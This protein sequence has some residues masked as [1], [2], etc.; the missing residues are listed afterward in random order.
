T[1]GVRG[2][3]ET[4]VVTSHLVLAIVSLIFGFVGLA[5]GVYQWLQQRGRVR[6]EVDEIQST[7][8]VRVVVD[9]PAPVHVS[10]IGFTIS[11]RGRLRRLLRRWLPDDAYGAQ[12]VTLR[13]K[14]A[15]MWRVRDFDLVMGVLEVPTEANE[16]VANPIFGFR[17]RQWS[18]ASSSI[19]K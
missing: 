4:R 6:V 5:F 19:C 9:A 17:R 7:I 18:S 8:Y 15:A 10:G 13:H 16:P 12:P 3:S 2:A 1:T 14:L 11:A